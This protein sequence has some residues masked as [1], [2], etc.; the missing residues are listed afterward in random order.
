M[1]NCLGILIKNSKLTT[2]LVATSGDTG[3][4]VANGFY[5]VKGTKLLYFILKIKLVKYKKDS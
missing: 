3:A 1:A 5:K 2:V 4:A